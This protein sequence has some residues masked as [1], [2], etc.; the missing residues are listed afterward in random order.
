MDKYDKYPDFVLILFPIGTYEKFGTYDELR[1]RHDIEASLDDLLKDKEIGF[2][3]G[4][5]IGGGRAEIFL[6]THDIETCVKLTK[7]ELSRREL[8]SFCTIK[9]SP[10][11]NTGGLSTEYKTIIE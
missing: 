11:G 9:S 7:K 8:L 6:H 5:L 10:Y 2:C 1:L 3:D 4:G